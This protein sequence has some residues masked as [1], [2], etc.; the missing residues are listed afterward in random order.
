MGNDY[1]QIDK[2]IHAVAPIDPASIQ[3]EMVNDL[4]HLGQAQDSKCKCFILCNIT[5]LLYKHDCYYS[6]FYY[7]IWIFSVSYYHCFIA[8]L[9]LL[10]TVVLFTWS[11][12]KFFA[13]IGKHFDSTILL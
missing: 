4:L 8:Y 12:F 9:A 13:F 1:S 2:K 10:F 7:F 11:V 5:V 3:V 6:V